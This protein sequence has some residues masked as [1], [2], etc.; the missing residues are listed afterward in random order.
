MKMITFILALVTLMSCSKEP[1][2]YPAPCEDCTLTLQV[3]TIVSPGSWKDANDYWHVKLN[4]HKYFTMES[5]MSDIH[6]RY[7]INSVPL[8]AVDWDSDYWVMFDSIGFKFKLFS[9][10]G[11][12]TGDGTRIPIGDTIITLKVNSQPTNI[13]GY[14]HSTNRTGG[15]E[16]RYSTYARKQIIFTKEMVG[17]TATIFAKAIWNTDM[18]GPSIERFQYQCV[19]FE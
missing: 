2:T 14:V 10:F 7:D 3:D 4:G 8:V 5:Q 19:I 6:S 18:I 12:V 11:Y 17:D 1:V 15:V 16:T 13:I 9:P